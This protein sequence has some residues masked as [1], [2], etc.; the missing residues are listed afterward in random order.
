MG[1]I[2]VAAAGRMNPS[3]RCAM[4]LAC[5]DRHRAFSEWG[6]TRPGELQLPATPFPALNQNVQ[7]NTQ[8]EILRGCDEKCLRTEA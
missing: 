3:D 8:I 7:C 2:I 1:T 5:S 4:M 6:V